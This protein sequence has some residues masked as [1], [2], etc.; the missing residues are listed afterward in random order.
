MDLGVAG[1]SPGSNGS[2]SALWRGSGQPTQSTTRTFPV[3]RILPGT[4]PCEADRGDGEMHGKFLIPM[5][6]ELNMFALN[7]RGNT[8]NSPDKA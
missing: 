5:C 2:V 6:N 3:K 8:G 4:L 1:V 7:R